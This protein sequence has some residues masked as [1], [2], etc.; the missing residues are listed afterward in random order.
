MPLDPNYIIAPSLEQYYVDKDTGLPLAN[1]VVTFYKDQAR[2]VLK[3]IYT[4]SGSPPNYTYVQLPNPVSL[5]ATGTFQDANGNNIIPYYF[6]HD[7]SG[8]IELY[9]ITVYSAGNVLQ[10]TRE[11]WPNFIESFSDEES[12]NLTNY[13]PNGQF[14]L[15]N[16]IPATTTTLVGQIT[17]PKTLIA[18]G[19]WSFDRPADSTATDFILFPRFNAFISNPTANPRYAVR[20][21]TTVAS[22]GDLFKDLRLTFKDVNKFANTTQ[23]FSFT[24]QTNTSTNLSLTILLIKNYG[25]KGSPEDSTVIKTVMIQNAPS[26]INQTIQFGNNI[27]KSIGLNDDDYVQ[28]V[29]RLPLSFIFDATFTDFILT[30][31]DVKLTQF[32]QTTSTQFIYRTSGY[33]P[34][35]NADGYDLY[36]PRIKT[37]EGE[38][39]DD[40]QIGQCVFQ[41]RKDPLPGELR[42]DGASY[43]YNEYSKEGI[44]YKRLGDVLLENGSYPKFG[45]G[46][47]FVSAK[48]IPTH[49]L[50]I[51]TN[52]A[53]ATT[54]ASPGT[55]GFT[56][57]TRVVG[58]NYDVIGFNF[59]TNYLYIKQ[60]S[61]G[62]IDGPVVHTA[63]SYLNVSNIRNGQETF[64]ITRVEVT[65]V[66]NGIAGKWFQFP[67]KT[68][69]YGVWFSVDGKGD[70]PVP[71]DVTPIKIDLS[72]SMDVNGR[73]S[74]IAETL[75]GHQITTIAV[76]DAASI[77]AGSYFQFS[78]NLSSQNYYVWYKKDNKGVD[79]SPGGIGIVVDI[80][81]T[82]LQ[83][84]VETKTVAAINKRYVTVPDSRNQFIRIWN[85]KGVDDPD[86]TQLRGF[87]YGQ[88]QIS[89]DMIGSL[90]LDEI[91]DHNHPSLFNGQYSFANPNVAINGYTGGDNSVNYWPTTGNFGGSESRA[92]NQFLNMFIKY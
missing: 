60:T 86:V 29:I 42:C 3:P 37:L 28:I 8:N 92:N 43:S 18:Q 91:Y 4:I 31:G 82:D 25:T 69:Q 1:G 66:D 45:T 38:Q 87:P 57:T 88:G 78:V 68:K 34:P 44:P 35:P 73:A 12:S 21:S 14:L 61:I 67:S 55:S 41:V 33:M 53:G 48:V 7:E 16:N 30:P 62:V 15:H 52:M 49:L 13:V 51:T 74:F 83:A 70:N 85:D 9:Y 11:G 75:G 90:Q 76:T 80:L 46:T 39:Y 20:I 56:I 58:N 81:G 79:P 84:D 65:S 36:L 63:S 27:G 17:Q 59:G 19:G 6:P 22:S 77:T 54:K 2:T 50:V 64:A 89:G 26:I 10:F 47:S 71:S 24:G 5:S 23:T 40:S 32:P 72:A